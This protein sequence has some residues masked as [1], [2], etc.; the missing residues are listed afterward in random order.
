MDDPGQAST[1]AGPHLFGCVEG[2][3]MTKLQCFIYPAVAALSLAAAFAA[4][5]QSYEGA[6]YDFASSRTAATAA[7]PALARAQVKAALAQA[8]AEGAVDVY[9]YGYNPAAQAQSLKTRA[10]VHAEVRALRGS[11]Y[12]QAW[13]GEDSGSF[14][15]SQQR[16][17]IAAAPVLA[18][19]PGKSG[20]GQ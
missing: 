9:G 14:V 11:N 18:A 17:A 16:P 12:A 4:H 15:M 20:A 8:R 13:Y 5:A 6:D 3:K 19:K 2:M 1:E 10:E 7:T